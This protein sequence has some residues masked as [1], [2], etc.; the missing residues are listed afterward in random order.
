[1]KHTKNIGQGILIGFLTLM[2]SQCNSTIPLGGN[3]EKID[4]NENTEQL[5][6]E[7]A[8]LKSGVASFRGIQSSFANALGLSLT[9]NPPICNTEYTNVK[10]NLPP[11]F[12]PGALS[13]AALA[14]VY[15]LALCF[16]DQFA[17]NA[18]LRAALLPNVN[19]TAPPSTSMSD[20]AK[21]EIANA[22]IGAAWDP[23][24]KTNEDVQDIIT[25]ISE[26]TPLAPATAAGTQNVV[27]T[28]CGVVLASYKS[29]SL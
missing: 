8:M 18:S 24:A 29:I 14:G 28:A 26:I 3:Q 5:K 19:F 4:Q 6:K 2:L 13:D 21:M 16:C 22:F 23:S 9:G 11:E 1:M 15:T 17:A 20:S 7:Q 25:L 12:N 10:G 27:A